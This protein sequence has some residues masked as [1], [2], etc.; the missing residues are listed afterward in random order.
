VNG[1][2]MDTNHVVAWEAQHP[3]LLAKVNSLPKNTLVFSSAI[4][5]GETS[6]GHE[7]TAGDPQRRHQVNQ[8]LNIYVIPYSVA[9]TDRTRSY[10]GQIM[11]RIWK[12]HPPSKASIS[13]DAHLVALGVN[14]N[15]VWIVASAWEH[16]LTLLTTDSMTVVREAAPEV[17]FEN[18]L[19]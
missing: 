2:L 17:T 14:M 18:W 13:S 15:D 16:G 12:Q 5:L 10:Y 1:Y 8:F 6:A 9:I 3:A 11:G 19:I 7:M 4:T